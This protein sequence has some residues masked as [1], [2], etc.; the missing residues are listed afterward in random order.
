MT[1]DRWLKFS[2]GD[3]AAVGSRWCSLL[4]QHH[5][6]AMPG[7]FGDARQRKA[8]TVRDR[9]ASHRIATAGTFMNKRAEIVSEFVANAEGPVHGV[10]FDGQSVWAATGDHLRSFDPATGLQGAAL[11]VPAHAGTAFDGRHLYQIAEAV[12]QKV[13][14]RTGEILATIPAPGAGRDSGLAWADG[15]LWV[16][17]FRGQEILQINPDTGEVRRRIEVNRFVTGVT[18]VDGELWHGYWDER[19]GGLARIDPAS[20][21]TITILDMPGLP[22]SGVESDG[23]DRFFCG[24]GDTGTVRIVRRR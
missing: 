22:V 11:A 24:G 18:W 10:T 23:A 7:G 21:K 17:Q 14:P 19:D 13:D 8:G 4:R 1:P 9:I 15:S 2:D 5:A 6:L 20:G 16:G 12:I 3:H